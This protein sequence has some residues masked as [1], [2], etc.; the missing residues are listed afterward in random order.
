MLII[1]T[2]QQQKSNIWSYMITDLEV[3]EHSA[4]AVAM[5]LHNHRS[6]V[7]NV[8]TWNA[9]LRGIDYNGHLLSQGVS[10]AASGVESSLQQ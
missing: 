3:Y 1:E 2:W 9:P 4:V 10:Q 6:S 8:Y 7:V 5:I